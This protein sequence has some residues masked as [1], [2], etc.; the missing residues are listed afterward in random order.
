[1]RYIIAVV[2]IVHFLIGLLIYESLSQ[3]RK[4]TLGMWS[5]AVIEVVVGK[6]IS[7]YDDIKGK[8][9]PPKIMTPG[10]ASKPMLSMF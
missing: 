10:F 2:F 7:F 4:R 9:V 6:G 3:D 5:S 8:E 1:M